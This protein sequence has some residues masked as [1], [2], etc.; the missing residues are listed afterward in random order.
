MPALGCR[1]N[2]SMQNLRVKVGFTRTL[3]LSIKSYILLSLSG[4]QVFDANYAC[5]DQPFLKPF[6][7]DVLF[8]Y[9]H[10]S[11]SP[12]T[13]HRDHSIPSMPITFRSKWY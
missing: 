4:L 2:Q 8:A 9:S 1:L 7:A 6:R 13:I 10:A 3:Y 11:R 12:N 5:L